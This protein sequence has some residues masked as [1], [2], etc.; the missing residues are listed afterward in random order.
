MKID[1]KIGE[2]SKRGLSIENLD[3][4]IFKLKTYYVSDAYY[5][6]DN[7]SETQIMRV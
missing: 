5:A 2:Q 3:R 6:M 1:G 4:C 7:S